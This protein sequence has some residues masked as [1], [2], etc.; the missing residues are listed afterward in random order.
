MYLIPRVFPV[1]HSLYCD[2]LAVYSTHYILNWFLPDK[3]IDLVDEATS[4]LC[5]AQESKPDALEALKWE[6]VTGLHRCNCKVKELGDAGDRTEIWI[7]MDY[8]FFFNIILKL[9]QY[10][11]YKTSN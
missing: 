2:Y 1:W 3:A 4:A 11:Q 6:I 5:L 10:D 8:S 7:P 9:N